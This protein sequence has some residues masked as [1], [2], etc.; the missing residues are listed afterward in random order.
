MSLLNNA[1]MRALSRNVRAIFYDS[2]K[3]SPGAAFINSIFL[4]IQSNVK[5][6]KFAFLRGIP[7]MRHWTGDRRLKSLS[8]ASFSIEK[9]DWEATIAVTRD[10]LQFD[11]LG[12]IRPNIEALGQSFPRHYVD[13]VVD[14]LANGFTRLAYDGQYFFDTDHDL[15]DGTSYSNKST[16][17]L[18]ATSWKVAELAPMGLKDPESGEFLEV[19]WDTIY[20]GPSAQADVD[21]LFNAEYIDG[22]GFALRNP[23][24]GKIKK[25]RQHV[26]RGLGASRKWFLTDESKPVKPL[27]L[28]IVKGVSFEAFDSSSDWNMF[29]RREAVYGIESQDNA[30]Y[31]LWELAY[32]STAGE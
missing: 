21:A 29:N 2:L 5:E 20:Y 31:G 15:G 10:D 4:I 23:H 25:D 6:E 26:L 19:S 12:L 18:D 32:G 22:G 8:E 28:Q 1:E 9:K 3:G 7:K 30:G 14:L 27:V 16:A 24:F 13:F 17:I 11:K